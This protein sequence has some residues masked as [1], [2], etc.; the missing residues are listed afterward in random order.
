MEQS[1]DPESS[2]ET[3]HEPPALLGDYRLPPHPPENYTKPRDL[4]T[5]ERLSL[6]HYIAWRK[7]NGTVQ[8]YHEHRKVLA[9]ASWTGILTLFRVRKLAASLMGFYPTRDLDF[10][11]HT[12]S[13]GELCRTPCFKSSSGLKKKP[14]A[15]VTILPVMETIKALFSNSEAAQKIRHHDTCLRAALDVIGNA[16][17]KYSDFS[18]SAIHQYQ[19]EQL[20]LFQDN[21][22]QLTMKKQSNT[23][24]LILIMLNL[25]PEIRYTSGNVIINLATPGPNSPET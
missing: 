4:A 21:G 15:Q 2:R 17:C 5:S 23:W 12:S 8:A 1:E 9:T 10:C 16:T 20:Q 11:P 18:N 14:S 22:A 24:L 6:Q 19:H 25:P 3:Q 13:T 7:S